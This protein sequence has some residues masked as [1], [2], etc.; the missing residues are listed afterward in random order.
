MRLHGHGRALFFLGITCLLSLAG[1]GSEERLSDELE[2]KLKTGI[3]RLI[4]TKRQARH[5]EMRKVIAEVLRVTGAD[6]ASAQKLEAAYAR[7]VEDSMR[8]WSENLVDA[9]R[10]MYR[11][12]GGQ[13]IENIESISPSMAL[14]PRN[15]CDGGTLPADQPS[16]REALK[17]ALTAGQLAK[18]DAEAA[19]RAKQ[20]EQEVAELTKSV[21][22]QFRDRQVNDLSLARSDLREGAGL[23]AAVEKK[24]EA[25]AA[26]LVD[27]L[28]PKWEAKLK[29]VYS[30]FSDEMRKSFL[31]SGA[32]LS[33]SRMTPR[34]EARSHPEWKKTVES[35]LT[36]G[37]LAIWS[38]KNDEIRTEAAKAVDEY[39]KNQSEVEHSRLA[40]EAESLA[41]EAAEAFKLEGEC[42]EKLRAASRQAA[43]E[44]VSLILEGRRKALL[45]MSEQERLQNMAMANRGVIYQNGP[46][47]RASRIESQPSWRQA[48]QAVLTADEQKRWQEIAS[49]RDLWQTEA[50]ASMVVAE[51]DRLVLLTASQRIEMEKMMRAVV[52]SSPLMS[53]YDG[54]MLAASYAR[55]LSQEQKDAVQRSLDAAQWRQ[56]ERLDAV[57][58]RMMGYREPREEGEEESSRP[59]ESVEQAVSDFLADSA[60]LERKERQE[61]MQAK[62]ED[63]KRSAGVSGESLRLLSIAAKGA[64]EASLR[65]WQQSMTSYVENQTRGA[66]AETVRSL[67]GESGELRI[68]FG[69]SGS[70]ADEKIWQ[71]MLRELLPAP[72][73][74]AWERELSARQSYRA[75]CIAK[76]A[77][78]RLDDAVRLTRG[79]HEKLLGE[80]RSIVAEYFDAF[81]STYGSRGSLQTY[82]L[83]TFIVGLP[84]P[85]MTSIL[86][87]GQWKVWSEEMDKGLKSQWDYIKSRKN[88]DGGN[89]RVRLFQVR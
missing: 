84:E 26:A 53:G 74:S 77:L 62:V 45:E 19:A 1:A 21:L 14:N 8:P 30:R 78:S 75:D 35:I 36:A 31:Q 48:L 10:G 43:D 44:R 16:W 9:W 33:A 63:V 60:D 25:A 20:K 83:S 42:L 41:A 18:W 49:A 71:D 56:W 88:Q 64:V 80:V 11:A 39:L 79:Q 61:A 73:K 85:V 22:E 29:V 58:S 7:A 27:R 4:P 6:A 70:P 23:D 28:A 17:T 72:Q 89:K 81:E 32:A 82:Y 65:E 37:Q 47:A 2:E 38:R 5:G 13:F 57:E 52:D 50:V 69:N 87:P 3:S 86:T 46:R 54:T 67:L 51:L 24:L 55:L 76:L 59:V 40:A 34:D 68:S 66:T 15:L 12:S